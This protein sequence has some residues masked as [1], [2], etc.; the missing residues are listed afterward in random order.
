MNPIPRA[1][2][3]LLLVL[4]PLIASGCY[5]YLPAGSSPPAPGTRIRVHLTE[6]GTTQLSG[7]LGP[8]IA[9]VDG[10]LLALT[11]SSYILS[12]TGV[13]SETG[14]EEF[15]TNER[16]ELTRSAVSRVEQRRL[17]RARTAL[18]SAGLASLVVGAVVAG[19]GGF[20]GGSSGGGR[21]GPR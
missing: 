2:L 19:N 9:S 13:V 15:W 6:T 10:N 14:A 12:V 4:V 21:P 5:H 8:R 11:D 1:F 17:D 16:A 7:Y 20:G 3:L 18:T